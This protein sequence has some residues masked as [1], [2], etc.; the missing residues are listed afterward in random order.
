MFQYDHR[1]DGGRDTRYYSPMTKVLLIDD[2]RKHS[3]LMQAYFKRFGIY[4]LC[5]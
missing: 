2:D 1:R 5:A 3:D 4:L